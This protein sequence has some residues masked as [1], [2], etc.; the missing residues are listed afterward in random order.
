MKRLFTLLFLLSGFFMFKPQ[1]MGQEVERAYVIQE[2]GT[3]TW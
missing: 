3:G 1:V 2:M